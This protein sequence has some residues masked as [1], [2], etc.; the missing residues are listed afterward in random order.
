V[1]LAAN[2]V[3]SIAQVYQ[4]AAAPRLRSAT[5]DRRYQAETGVSSRRRVNARTPVFFYTVR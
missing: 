4:S 5:A 2:T 3:R 1:T